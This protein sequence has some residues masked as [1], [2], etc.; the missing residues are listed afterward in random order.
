[1]NDLFIGN[2][3]Y[4]FSHTEN[5]I[6]LSIVLCMLHKN[7]KLNTITIASGLVV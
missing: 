2:Q 4:S 6:A 1:M 5:L 7:A 3:N